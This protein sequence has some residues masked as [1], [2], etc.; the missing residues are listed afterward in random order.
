M[1][2]DRSVLLPTP[3]ITIDTETIKTVNKFC[4][5]GY[6]LCNTYCDTCEIRWRIGMAKQACIALTNVWKDRSMNQ[7]LKNNLLKSLVFSIATCGSKSWCLKAIDRKKL[8]SFQLWC[9]FLLLRC[10]WMDRCTN[11]WVLQQIGGDWRLLN[12]IHHSKPSCFG[13]VFRKCNIENDCLTG[14]VC[15]KRAW[16]V[17]DEVERSNFQ[18]LI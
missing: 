1:L 15:G 7:G 18:R 8:K 4:Y 10:S 13:Q 5:L 14:M 17:Q 16:K 6:T 3:K 12:D 11:N 2:I 9:Y